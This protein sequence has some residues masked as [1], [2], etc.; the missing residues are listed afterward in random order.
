MYD[1]LFN[2]CTCCLWYWCDPLPALSPSSLSG[3]L[4]LS[5]SC[6]CFSCPVLSNEQTLTVLKNGQ[7][8][9]A[10]FRIQM[11]KFVGSSYKDVFLHC[12]VQICHNTLG[13][14]QPV[15]DPSPFLHSDDAHW[16]VH[17]LVYSKGLLLSQIKTMKTHCFPFFIFTVLL[18]QLVLI[19]EMW[20]FWKM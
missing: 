2:G 8:P 12:N 16:L 4:S 17:T 10:M 11:F 9:E 14:C 7:G 20:S 1:I 13:V 15:S 6:V 19:K 5:L 3:F 18:F